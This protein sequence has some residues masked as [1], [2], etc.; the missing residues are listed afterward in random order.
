MSKI[1]KL[2]LTLCTWVFLAGNAFA[3]APENG[4]WW[5]PSE[6]GSATP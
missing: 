6:S 5:N 4:W 3:V 2:F 1:A